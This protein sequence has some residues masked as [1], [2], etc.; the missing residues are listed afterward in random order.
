MEFDKNI[1]TK[2]LESSLFNKPKLITD[3]EED[4]TK[5][6]YHRYFYLSLKEDILVQEG[7][8]NMVVPTGVFIDVPEGM[9][10]EIM[11]TYDSNC[12][13]ECGVKRKLYFSGEHEIILHLELFDTSETIDRET[14]FV[15]VQII[16]EED[17]K[18]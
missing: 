14:E 10:A 3:V 13:T 2:H 5:K 9:V 12:H 8:K 11:D 18:M 7:T 4:G 17:F 15:T 1:I 16:K 6:I